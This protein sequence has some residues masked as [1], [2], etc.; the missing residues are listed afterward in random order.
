[1]A[2]ASE[3]ARFGRNAGGLPPVR[4]ATVLEIRRI[5]FPTDFSE[6]ADQAFGTALRLAE[7]H[8]AELHV[9]HAVV[10]HAADPANPARR[11]PDEDRVYRELR[12]IAAERMASTAG[13]HET[14]DIRIERAQRR[15]ISA[16]PAILD[17]V[18]EKDV[19][20]VV[21]GTHGRRALGRMLLGSVA[22]EVLR[23]APCPVVTVRQQEDAPAPGPVRRIA[24]PVDFSDHSRLGYDYAVALAGVFD[25]RLQ[26]LHVVEEALYPDFYYP[27][28]A[29]SPEANPEL[30]ERVKEALREWLRD[31]GGDEALTEIHV[32]AGRAAPEIARFLEEKQVDLAVLC[33][34]GRTG[35]ERVLLG[36]VAEGV[37]RRAHCPVLVVKAFGKRLLPD[38]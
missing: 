27:I 1:M 12:E 17:Y 22:R 10:L 7:A 4:Q 37:V 34:H 2:G 36:S 8:G 3:T 16:V 19:D 25:A 32:T 24:V 15:A 5:L 26:L 9:L 28:L 11:F 18:E 38:G 23:A 31:V 35:V 6:G 21:M 30:S 20:L 14:G 33:S 29:T 13:R